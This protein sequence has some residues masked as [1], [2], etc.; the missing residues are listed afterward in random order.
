VRRRREF[1][2][3]HHP[4]RGGDPAS[5]IAG[6]RALDAEQALNAPEPLPRVIIVRHRPWLIRLASKAVRRLRHEREPPRVR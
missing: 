2:W 5:F 4:D 6:M 1:I 3:L